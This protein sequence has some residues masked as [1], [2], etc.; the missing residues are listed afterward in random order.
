M[1]QAVILDSEAQKSPVLSLL[2]QEEFE[3]ILIQHTRWLE[4]NG[5][6]G[7]RA[8]LSA[9]DLREVNLA[10][11]HSEF[12][13]IKRDIN[14]SNADLSGADVSGTTL[15]GA[16]LRGADFSR[17]MGIRT[18]LFAADLSGANLTGCKFAEA[19]FSQV[20]LSQAIFEEA[21]LKNANLFHANLTGAR[22]AKASFREAN[23]SEADLAQADLRDACLQ[24]AKLPNI[25]GL[26]A[27]QL[28]GTHLGGATLPDSINKFEG[29]TQV[30]NISKIG[31]KLFVAIML[32]CVYAWLTIGSTTDTRLLTNTAS[33]PLPILQTE[34]PIASFY[35][36]AP[37]VLLAIYIY[38]HL[39]LH[40][41]W[42]TLAGLPAFFPDGRSLNEKA[43]PWLFSG[44]VRV[45]M[46][47][48]RPYCGIF[49]RMEHMALI[50][51]GWWLVPITLG[52]CWLRA[53][54]KHDLCVSGIQGIT[55]WA[56]II[57]GVIFQTNVKSVLRGGEA[58]STHDWSIAAYKTVSGSHGF[59]SSLD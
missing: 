7:Q 26:L 24:D 35:W 42:K 27:H 2:K 38:F 39:Y 56:A 23:L 31:G 48:L 13:S 19:N 34:I 32:G 22:L 57:L 41:L 29:L 10:Q 58:F 47:L 54:P 52:L 16:N 9:R 8:D 28:G 33:S 45:H 51:L 53:L 30:E 12:E 17:A 1:G 14:L 18:S 46:N 20:S 44:L 49:S 3:Q 43:Y 25:R 40:R 55:V 5:E 15:D 21:D 36:A 59:L 11:T 37:L 6:E 50:F 4:T